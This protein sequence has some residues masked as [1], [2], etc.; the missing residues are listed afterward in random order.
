VRGHFHPHGVNRSPVINDL[1]VQS[2]AGTTAPGRAPSYETHALPGR[3]LR[4]FKS[5]QTPRAA[6]IWLCF[7]KS[8]Q[9]RNFGSQRFGFLRKCSRN[10]RRLCFSKSGQPLIPVG[11]RQVKDDFFLGPKHRGRRY[12]IK[13]LALSFQVPSTAGR[14]PRTRTEVHSFCF[15]LP[16]SDS[17]IS[18]PTC[19]RH[20]RN[21]SI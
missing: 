11:E 20:F 13:A 3:R 6:M 5:L 9:P 12:C 10:W 16:H 8:G 1:F 4:F 21:G 18:T 7:F 15:I 2:R 14:E 19:S 17:R